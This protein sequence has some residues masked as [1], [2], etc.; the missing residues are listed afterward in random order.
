MTSNLLKNSSFPIVCI[1]DPDVSDPE[2]KK[3][4]LDGKECWT[5][6]GKYINSSDNS[7]G[8]DINGMNKDA[9]IAH[10][11]RWLESKKLGYSKS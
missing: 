7:T 1:Q 2:Q 5:E 10:I 11:T 8:I 6:D 3:R 4:I 9:G